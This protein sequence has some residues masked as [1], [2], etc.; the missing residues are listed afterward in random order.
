MTFA[1]LVAA[2]LALPLAAFAH[3]ESSDG[4]SPSK[5]MSD[6]ELSQVHA[7]GLPSPALQNMAQGLP[8]AL[9]E[10][11][12]PTLNAQDLNSQV[13]R[14]QQAM[15]QLRLAQAAT[16]GSIG[17]MQT[18]SLPALLTPVAP[19]FIP[20]LAMPFPFLMTPP[21]KKAEPGH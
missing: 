3:V 12:V 16:Q 7:A 15:S 8:L 21:P 11:P 18:V 6:E 10:M 14:Q 9:V 2:C 19:L 5:R 1:R 20:V 17:M 4:I 13:D